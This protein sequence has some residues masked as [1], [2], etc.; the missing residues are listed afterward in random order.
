MEEL[1]PM[2]YGPMWTFLCVLARIGPLM[3]MMP[4]LRGSSVPVQI[5]VLIALMLGVVITPIAMGDATPVPEALPLLAIQIAKELLLG[6]LLGSAAMIVVSCLQVGGQIVSQ[7]AGLDLATAADPAT[8]DEASVISQL[9]SWLT[10]ALFLVLGGHR[11]FFDCCI[12]T[13]HIYPAGGVLA[14]EHWLMHLHQMV[15]HGLSVGIRA[16][17]PL[18]LSVFLSNLVTAL[19][20]RSL[21]QLNVIAV[22]FNINALVMLSILVMTLGSVGWLYQNE[23]SGWIEKTTDLFA[24]QVTHG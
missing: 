14:E 5:R 8:E 3:S 17:A 7:L 4:P 20:N 21:P 18:A 24:G 11:Q 6:V 15:Q 16:T 23:L 2:L 9:F 19:I 22:G 12:E 10:M 1:Y 13:F